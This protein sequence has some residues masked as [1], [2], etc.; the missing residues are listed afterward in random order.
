L[1]GD[2]FLIGR[3]AA[4]IAR[5]KSANREIGV[6]GLDPFAGAHYGL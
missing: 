4:V 6:P 3:V 5:A 2:L 1:I